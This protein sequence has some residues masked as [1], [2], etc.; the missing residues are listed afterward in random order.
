M[1]VD[2]TLNIYKYRIPEAGMSSGSLNQP[3]TV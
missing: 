1:D 2:G 3:F